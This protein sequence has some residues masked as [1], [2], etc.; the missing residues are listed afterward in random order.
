MSRFICKR[1]DCFAN[2]RGMCRALSKPY[3]GPCKFYKVRTPENCPEA[4]DA[5]VKMYSNSQRGK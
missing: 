5:A 3:K 2:P 1:K 4:I